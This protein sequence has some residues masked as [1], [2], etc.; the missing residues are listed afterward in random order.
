MYLTCNS[1]NSSPAVTELI[2]LLTLIY[3]RG[4]H[5]ASRGSGVTS[6]IVDKY[7]YFEYSKMLSRQKHVSSLTFPQRSQ[8]FGNAHL[9]HRIVI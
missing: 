5:P 7:S 1:S 2:K 8:T 3:F 6:S 9:V 4:K